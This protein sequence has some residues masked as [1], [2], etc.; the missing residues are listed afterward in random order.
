[1]RALPS[2]PAY[3]SQPPHPP[4]VLYPPPHALNS[5]KID[6]TISGTQVGILTSNKPDRPWPN[7]VLDNVVASGVGV[8]IQQEGGKTILASAPGA[9]VVWTSGM[10][11]IGGKG[12]KPSGIVDGLPAKDPSLTA[13]G[14]LFVKSRPQYETIGRGGLLIATE[15]GIA[16]DG[17]TD[18]HDKINT[19]L[20]NAASQG[21][22][23]FFPAGIYLITD[24][25]FIPV[26]S[27]VQGSSWSQVRGQ[28]IGR[29]VGNQLT[30]L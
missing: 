10:R 25:I 18:Q 5:R 1:M 20:A 21:K 22:I 8:F 7:V 4:I 16:N 24:T 19:F 15:N 30:S 14:K 2:I 29:H 17:K 12:S 28:Y 9:G 26:G 23:A 6:S 11:Y 3:F 27:K 13:G